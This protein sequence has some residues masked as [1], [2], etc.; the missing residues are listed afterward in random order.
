M[1]S[2]TEIHPSAVVSATAS[3]G[4]GVSIGAFCVIGDHVSIGDN[5]RIHHHVVIEGHTT[6]GA[7][8]EIFPFASLGLPPQH[9]QYQNEPSEL[10]I[11]QNNLIR[12]QVTMHRGTAVDQMKTIVG[13]NNLI[14]VGCHI[15]HDCVVGNHTIMANYVGLGGHVHVGDYAYL[16][17][18]SA[19]HQYVKIGAYA[20]IGGQS[21]IVDNV[22]P[23]GNASG[24]RATLNGLN[25][26]GMK[27]RGYSKQQINALRTVFQTLFHA[28]GLFSERLDMVRGQYKDNEDVQM[29]LSFIEQAKDRELCHPAR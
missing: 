23:F 21:A 5:V 20:M 13:D 3:L 22:I 29:I 15:A 14:F 10:I 26:V 18:Y 17:A 16:G 1:S 25:L 11:G 7:G 4:S 2:Q 9:L 19:F 8:T 27:R 6:I 24:P 12:E 28:D